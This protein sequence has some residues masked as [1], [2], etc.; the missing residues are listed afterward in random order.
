MVDE[1]NEKGFDSKNKRCDTP[2]NRPARNRAPANLNDSFF[3]EEKAPSILF[4]SQAYEREMFTK[5]LQDPKKHVAQFKS[6]VQPASALFRDDEAP[7]LH[8][9]DLFLTCLYAAMDHQK[10][11]KRIKAAITPTDILTYAE[12]MKIFIREDEDPDRLVASE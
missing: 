9:I 12:K 11:T 1:T 8:S 6:L 4:S 3:S 7:S 10:N 5:I 2:M